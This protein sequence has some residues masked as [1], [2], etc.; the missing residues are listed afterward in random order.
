[1]AH[2]QHADVYL[3][4]REEAFA[5]ALEIRG[6]PVNAV[7]MESWMDTGIFTLVALPDAVSF[8]YSNG[9]GDLGLGEHPGPKRER[10]RL[11]VLAAS[12]SANAVPVADHPLPG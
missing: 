6:R 5:W 9:G 8:Y 4:I 12:F 2:Q 1:M 3:G 10:D 11:L 7:V